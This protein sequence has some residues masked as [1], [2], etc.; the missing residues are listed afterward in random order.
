VNRA[1][2]EGANLSGSTRIGALA[3][4]A[5][6]DF[7]GAHDDATDRRLARR[8]ANQQSVSADWDG[9]AWALGAAWLRVGKRPDGGATLPADATLDLRGLWR[10]APAWTVEAKVLNLTD[11][12]VHP[13]LDYQG[14]GRQAWIG[15]RYDGTL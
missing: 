8:A 11:R 15:V 6:L 13:A 10:V 14:L 1:T 5:Q 7:L 3:L 4:A 2:L 9:G 12:D